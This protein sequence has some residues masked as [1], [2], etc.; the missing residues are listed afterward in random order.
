[1]TAWLIFKIVTGNIP[2]DSGHDDEAI[3]PNIIGKTYEQVQA[4]YPWMK[5][6]IKREYSMEFEEYTIMEQLTPAN[7]SIKKSHTVTIVISNGPK[8]I[9]IED[10]TNLNA[11][12]AK[13]KLE[14]SD[15]KVKFIKAESDDIP[16]GYVIKTDPAAHSQVPQGTEVKVYVSLGKGEKVVNV[17]SFIGKTLDE[18]QKLADEKKLILKVIYGSSNEFEKG[19]II[20]Q[21]VDENSM[22]NQETEI[23]VTVCDGKAV[24][25]ETTI[26]FELP[27][28]ASDTGTF[29]FEYF[30]D[31]V[32]FNREER[33]MSMN[34]GNTVSFDVKG[35]EKVKY[36]VKITS[37]LFCDSFFLLRIRTNSSNL[38]SLSAPVRYFFSKSKR[39]IYILVN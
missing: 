11:E 15:L 32:R 17:P 21:N 27:D 30:K 31:G 37:F 34:A 28:F 22:V 25:N 8:K 7:R 9:N 1:M 19:Q 3:M 14:K 6:D 10:L 4:E 2:T 13:R 38:R 20:K 16:E 26:E 24:V 39:A 29:I 36:A 35:S 12:D 5:L 33:D 23:E 18:A